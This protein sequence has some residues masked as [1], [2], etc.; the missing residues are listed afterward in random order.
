MRQHPLRAAMNPLGQYLCFMAE[1]HGHTTIRTALRAAGMTRRQFD[2]LAF[3][4]RDRRESTIRRAVEAFGGSM[5]GFYGRHWDP[6]YDPALDMA[7]ALAR[8]AAARGRP[9]F[10]RNRGV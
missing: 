8:G 1:F 4:R 3:G 2:T 9:E 7:C 5:Y 6:T 10:N